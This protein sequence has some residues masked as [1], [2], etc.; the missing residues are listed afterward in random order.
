[1]RNSC[2]VYL[3]V[4]SYKISTFPFTLQGRPVIRFL[5]T[6]LNIKQSLA[7]TPAAREKLYAHNMNLL[8]C[9]TLLLLLLLLMQTP[10]YAALPSPAIV[11]LMLTGPVVIGVCTTRLIRLRSSLLHVRLEICSKIIDATH[12]TE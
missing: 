11:S 5:V 12:Y 3:N 6:G 7:I 10:I 1:M 8:L 4:R 9:I 2:N